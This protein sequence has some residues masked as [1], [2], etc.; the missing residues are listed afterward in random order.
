MAKQVHLRVGTQHISPHG[1]LALFDVGDD[2]GQLVAKL[3]YNTPENG[4]KKIE[5]SIN[6][7]KNVPGFGD[8]TLDEARPGGTNSRDQALVTIE[9]ES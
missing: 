8:V 3:G 9:N 5:L 6:E 2:H 1:R 4:R 7:T